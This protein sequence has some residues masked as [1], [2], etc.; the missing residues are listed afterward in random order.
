MRERTRPDSERYS[1]PEPKLVK[2]RNLTR[3]PKRWGRIVLPPV[4]S[5]LEGWGY[6]PWD[7]VRDL[8]AKRHPHYYIPPESLGEVGAVTDTGPVQDVKDSDVAPPPPSVPQETTI[9]VRVEER[10]EPTPEPA[11]V[12]VT[13]PIVVLSPVTWGH[14]GQGQAPVELSRAFAE[15]G[16]KVLYIYGGKV[17]SETDYQIP[18]NVEVFGP[19]PSLQWLSPGRNQVSDDVIAN[20]VELVASRFDDSKGIVLN[21]APF[22]AFCK[23]ALAIKKN[24]GW[25]YA[26]H[27]LD[28][29]TSIPENERVQTK[30]AVRGDYTF[31]QDE[32][33]MYDGEADSFFCVSNVLQA[34][35]MVGLS[36]R[37]NEDQGVLCHI[38]PNG[39]SADDFP[40]FHGVKCNPPKDLVRGSPT[41][42]FWGHMGCS[43]FDWER[44]FALAT[45]VPECRVNM[46]GS[47]PS[48]RRMTSLMGKR[49]RNVHFLGFKPHGDLWKYGV[50]S[51]VGIVPFRPGA[52]AN[53]ANPIKV[54]EYLACMIPVVALGVSDLKGLHPY[55]KLC[56]QTPTFIRR[57]QEMGSLKE[58]GKVDTSTLRSFLSTN[59]W[60]ARAERFLELVGG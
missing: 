60:V 20:I 55:V 5:Y 44:V 26:Y 50:N 11:P 28:D 32:L 1:R 23:L 12:S 35:A 8:A 54:W 51:H 59:T 38:L 46:I 9:E 31:F 7:T 14:S 16:S 49:P 4:Q 42:I 34:K 15:I 58:D 2:I 57:V 30:C 41:V 10:T 24:L 40:P 52:V 36:V 43:W 27:C 18:S 53:A 33:D 22:P 17:E 13:R 3:F 48:S 19:G 29:W 21:T 39:F 25:R 45:Q 56:G 37:R 6:L 47:L